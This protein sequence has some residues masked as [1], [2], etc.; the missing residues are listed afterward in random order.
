SVRVGMTRAPHED[1][2]RQAG[3]HESIARFRR[4]ARIQAALIQARIKPCEK[5]SEHENEERSERREL[6]RS[7][8]HAER[9]MVH[10]AIGEQY[11]RAVRLLVQRE[12]DQA[13]H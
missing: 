7:P 13:E 12:K 2:E 1:Q 11:P 9:A 8:L 5:W 4:L 3:E 6:A 10:H